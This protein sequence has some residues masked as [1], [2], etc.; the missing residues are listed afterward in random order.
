MK[1][2][3][4]F[5][6]YDILVYSTN[7]TD[8]IEHLRIVLAILKLNKLFAKRSKCHFGVDKVEYLGHVISG[9]GIA[10]EPTKIA[11]VQ[12]WPIPQTLKGLR[13]FLGLTGYYRKFIKG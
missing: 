10:T 5:F 8:H 13:G 11:T 7:L 1:I 3:S 9:Q 4:S 12:N 2:H 6:F